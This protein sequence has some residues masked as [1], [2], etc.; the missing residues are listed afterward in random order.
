MTA[1]TS[2]KTLMRTSEL[3]VY[4]VSECLVCVRVRGEA[5]RKQSNGIL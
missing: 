1:C 5:L 4:F 2:S 3:R